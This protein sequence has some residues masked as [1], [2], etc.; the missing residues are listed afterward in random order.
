MK[1]LCNRNFTVRFTSTCRELTHWEDS[2]LVELTCSSSDFW[3]HCISFDK[4]YVCSVLGLLSSLLHSPNSSLR[5]TGWLVCHPLL[6]LC[7]TPRGHRQ[8][9]SSASDWTSHAHSHPDILRY[10]AGS[11]CTIICKMMTA[12]TVCMRTAST[13]IT[14]ASRWGGA[15]GAIFFHYHYFLS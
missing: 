7:C 13:L 8:G 15:P 1:R 3:A 11:I 12:T 4:S 5:L 9:L 2:T 14:N 10:R 6:I